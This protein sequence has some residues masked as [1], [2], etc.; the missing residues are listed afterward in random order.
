MHSVS[1]A[2]I[3]HQSDFILPSLDL[4]QRDHHV[5][6]DRIDF[7]CDTYCC[8]DIHDAIS[9]LDTALLTVSEDV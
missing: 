8:V 9:V 1:T 4:T 6:A 2:S 7:S 5:S 3:N